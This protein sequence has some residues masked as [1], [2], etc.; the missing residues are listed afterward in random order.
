MKKY[1]FLIIA[2]LSLKGFSQG[3]SNSNTNWGCPNGGKFVGANFFGFNAASGAALQSDATGSQTWGLVDMNGDKKQDLVVFGQ[4]QGGLVSCFSPGLNQYWQVYLNTG[5]GFSITAI[6]WSTPDGGKRSGTDIYGYNAISGTALPSDISGSQSWSLMDM[7]G[8][9]KPDLVITAQKQGSLVT[10]FSPITGQYWKVHK[11]T[12]SGF[13]NTVTNWDLPVGGKIILGTNYGF[14][15]VSNVAPTS[16]ATGS[17]TWGLMDMDG[18]Y[19][20]DLIVAAQKQGSEVMCFGAGSAPYWKVYNNTGSGFS[21]AA[22]NWD[23]PFGGKKLMNKSTFGFNNLN[24]TALP[25]EDT[26]AQTWA[27]T[28]MDGDHKPDLV[29]C[30]Q[31]QGG[32]VTCFSVGAGPYWKVYFNASNKFNTTPTNWNLPNGGFITGGTSYG[33]N[34]ISGTSSQV[35]NTNSQSWALLNLDDYAGPDLVVTAQ[36]S[37]GNITCLGA[38]IDPHWLAYDNLSTGFSTSSIKWKLPTGG[39]ISGAVTYGFDAVSGTALPSHNQNSQTW[40]ITDLNGDF[41]LD[42]VVA[43]QYQPG[44]VTSFSPTS[45]QYWKVYDGDGVLGVEDYSQNKLNNVLVYPNPNTGNFTIKGEATERLIIYNE[46][47][48]K[49]QTVELNEENNFTKTVFDLKNGIYFLSSK[50]GSAKVAVSR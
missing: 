14:D 8:D 35:D 44:G 17:Q 25:S 1:F 47:G 40:F 16:D 23:L 2:L 24:G 31:L 50:N 15:N 10:S 29:V 30:A 5:S 48:Q 4:L 3:F 18:D 26:G 19:K 22:T 11:N 41:K 6:N 43:G 49:V 37:A 33:F 12:G 46:L 42:L 9:N 34:A 39:K 32:L 20:P 27:L 36:H 45:S 13:S 21:L 28:D 7:D 38:G